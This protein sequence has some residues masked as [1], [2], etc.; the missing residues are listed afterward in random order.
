MIGVVVLL[1]VV[2]VA[3]VRSS[4]FFLF[5]CVCVCVCLLLFSADVVIQADVPMSIGIDPVSMSGV[6][7]KK[8][9]AGVCE[10]PNFEACDATLVSTRPAR[11]SCCV[12]GR[13]RKNH[14]FFFFPLR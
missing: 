4:F 5:A 10:N 14:H 7:S 12:H 9:Q 6:M 1:S 11:T 2:A 13:Q 3:L 8:R